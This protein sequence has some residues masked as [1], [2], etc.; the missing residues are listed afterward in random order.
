[1]N[2]VR[3]TGN[4][5]SNPVESTTKNNK[6]KVQFSIAENT[7][8]KDTVS[9]NWFPIIAYGSLVKYIMKNGQ[10]GALAIIE[11]KLVTYKIEKTTR[12]HIVAREI[13]IVKNNKSETENIA[14]DYDSFGEEV[15]DKF[16]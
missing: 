11:G 4:L 8:F 10:K 6:P 5:G 15:C 13:R 7:Y 14:I 3:I 9:T 1:M 16:E 12:F 2:S